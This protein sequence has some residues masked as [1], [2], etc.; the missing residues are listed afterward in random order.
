MLLGGCSCAWGIMRALAGGSQGLGV[1]PHSCCRFSTSLV[2]RILACPLVSGPLRLN[3]WTMRVPVTPQKVGKLHR[4]VGRYAAR[5]LR[6]FPWRK[7]TSPYRVLIAELMLQRT[8]AAQV[9]PVF[10]RFVNRFPGLV[11]AAQAK[12]TALAKVLFPLGRTDRH[13]VFRKAFQYIAANHN[14]RVPNRLDQLLKVPAV[15]PYTARAVLC[16]AYRQRVGLLDPNVYR[17]LQRVFGIVSAKKRF[18]TDAGLWHIV[19]GIAPRSGVRAFNWALLDI[20]ST[21]CVVR[22]PHCRRCPLISVCKY[23]RNRLHGAA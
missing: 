9:T 5:S 16:F 6:R 19:D 18:H 21:L 22:E 13:R 7:R 1:C 2:G 8:G 15:G 4:L 10:E 3:L 17:L 14:G 23:G 20:A 12:P 11:A